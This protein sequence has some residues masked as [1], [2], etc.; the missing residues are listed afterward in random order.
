MENRSGPLDMLGPDP[1]YGLVHRA[2]RA[3]VRK[4]FHN[5]PAI[6]HSTGENEVFTTLMFWFSFQPWALAW[7]VLLQVSLQTCLL[8][9]FQRLCFR[10][11][12]C[13]YGMWR[14]L[15]PDASR[16]SPSP[17]SA[18]QI[19]HSVTTRS[20]LHHFSKFASLTPEPLPFPHTR[21]LRR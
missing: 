8:T 12:L 10:R 20:A 6:A 13:F 14:R 15:F 4:D 19:Q 21:C 11:T 7:G 9:L 1:E 5:S 18:R 16:F 2:D 17:P 3:I